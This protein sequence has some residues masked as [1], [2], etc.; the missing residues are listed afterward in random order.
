[1]TLSTQYLP[2]TTSPAVGSKRSGRGLGPAP[3]RLVEEVVG[4]RAT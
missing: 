2:A 1:M 4:G 3:S